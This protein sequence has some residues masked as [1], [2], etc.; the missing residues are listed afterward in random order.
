M[1]IQK[2]VLSN[3][4]KLINDI[5]I[6]DTQQNDALD[7]IKLSIDSKRS[8]IVIDVT[9]RVNN[10]IIVT[11]KNADDKIVNMYSWYI[12]SGRNMSSIK[13]YHN[14]G[15]GLY[16]IEIGSIHEEL[17]WRGTLIIR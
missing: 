15:P 3:K 7:T 13:N 12:M 17:L 5:S 14:C 1:L 11:M 10:N 2:N 4:K 16:K 8:R 6:L 9:S